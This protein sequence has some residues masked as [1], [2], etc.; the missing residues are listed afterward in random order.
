MLL[1]SN[2][3]KNLIPGLDLKRGRGRGRGDKPAGARGGR[4]RGRGRG[5][6]SDMSLKPYGGYGGY[7]S[8]SQQSF[9]DHP[10]GVQA[11]PIGQPGPYLP[12][13]HD[14]GPSGAYG[15]GAGRGEF[16]TRFHPYA[17]PVGRVQGGTAPGM[18]GYSGGGAG[19]GREGYEQ[20]G[21][22]PAGNVPVGGW[23][24]PPVANLVAN[25]GGA[26]GRGG[27]VAG[28]VGGV[29]GQGFGRERD[30]S[31]DLPQ[32]QIPAKVGVEQNKGLQV[33]IATSIYGR[34]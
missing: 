18:G 4:G 11:G 7:S 8:P 10:H 22:M 32:Q 25:L 2:S 23:G 34:Y 13:Q 30:W 24:A 6:M 14:Y 1:G 17:R 9:R 12:R 21:G 15:S 3:G 5:F 20:G 27:V 31:S 19:I 16:G 26:W 29:G 33:S 28:L